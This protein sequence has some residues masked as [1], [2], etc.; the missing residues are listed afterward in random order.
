MSVA[1]MVSAGIPAPVV[2]LLE[3]AVTVQDAVSSARLS[4]TVTV[5]SAPL[6]PVPAAPSPRSTESG[7]EMNSSPL[8]TVK[9]TVVSGS[10]PLWA[11]PAC[12]VLPALETCVPA[13]AA[14]GT[15][16]IPVAVAVVS[17]IAIDLRMNPPKYGR[18][19]SL[20]D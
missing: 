16:S 2:K 8:V 15:S 13:N 7:T 17:R 5:P 11:L 4:V 3:D 1:G 10:D 19:R 18:E 14:V 12:L 6:M 9:V 20:A